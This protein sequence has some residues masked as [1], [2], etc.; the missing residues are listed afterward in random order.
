MRWRIPFVFFVMMLLSA[1]IG[2]AEVEFIDTS[3]ENASPLWY[4]T[5]PEGVIRV[6]LVY[7]HEWNAPNRAAGHIHFRIHAR[8]GAKLTFEFVNL[9]NIWNGTRVKL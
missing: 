2:A 4:D 7:D 8:P 9:D 3:I 6:H 1:A 5:T